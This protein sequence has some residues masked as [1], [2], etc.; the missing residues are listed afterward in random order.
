MSD[1]QREVFLPASSQRQQQRGENQE[2]ARHFG[3]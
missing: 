3:L 2:F 1:R